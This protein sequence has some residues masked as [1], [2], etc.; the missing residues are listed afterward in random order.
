MKWRGVSESEPEPLKATLKEELDQRRTMMRRFVPPATQAVNDRA[1]AEFRQ[2]ELAANALRVGDMAPEFTLPDVN[3]NAV[4]S[5]DLLAKGPLVVTFVRG[6]WCPFC[7]ATV[8]AWQGMLGD[9]KRAGAT[10]VAI[11]PML[12]KQAD[13]MRDQ[14]KLMFPILNDAG[15][16]V[17]E[18]FGVAYTVPKY[19]QEL[20]ATVFI[21]LP[22]INGDESWTLP[23]PATFVIGQDGR[24]KY[25][26]VDEDYTQRA[27]PSEVL[28]AL[29]VSR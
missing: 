1:I 13:F 17:A 27:E 18:Q 2:A 25:A 28:N 24:V 7:C 5:A 20:F 19:Q 21:N 8:E 6:R 3:G 22:F 10:V 15:N 14:H 4:R 16:K 29:G 12:S 11:S 23:L 26:F 9:V